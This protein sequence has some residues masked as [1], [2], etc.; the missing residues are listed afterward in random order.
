M[1]VVVAVAAALILGVMD[2][3]LDELTQLNTSTIS[4]IT[5]ASKIL[6][7]TGVMGAIILLAIKK[8]SETI[9]PSKLELIVAGLLVP[10]WICTVY[11]I[12]NAGLAARALIHCSIIVAIAIA[13]MEGAVITWPTIVSIVGLLVATVCTVWFYLKDNPRHS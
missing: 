6:I 8:T 2:Y 5:T 13:V 10:G 11:C 3:K 7:A 4:T 9:M 12:A 1:I